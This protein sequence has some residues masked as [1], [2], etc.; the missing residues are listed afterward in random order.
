MSNDRRAV[1][2]ESDEDAY[3]RFRFAPA[4]KV[5]ETVY[6]SGVIGR[7][8]DGKVPEDTAAEVAALFT[9]LAATLHA[10]GATLN[11]IV[12]ITSF[13][14]DMA[15]VRELVEAKHDLISEPY[16]AWTA[17]GCSGLVMPG[18]RVELKATAVISN[19][20]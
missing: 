11:D 3:N 12:D 10:A 16:P 1:V 2:P 4:F 19:S 7:G 5:G 9:Q 20:A 8:P 18:A 13:H 6:V 14:V 15:G 17:I